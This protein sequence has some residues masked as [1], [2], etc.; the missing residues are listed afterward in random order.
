MYVLDKSII[1]VLQ[2]FVSRD[3]DEFYLEATELKGVYAALLFLKTKK[4]KT[5][6]L[7]SVRLI[8]K[9]IHRDLSH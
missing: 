3:T 7:F 9:S 4:N 6:V 1:L 5:F 8:F 2:I